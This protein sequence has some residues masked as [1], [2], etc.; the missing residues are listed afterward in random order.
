VKTKK[1]ILNKISVTLKSIFLLLIVG[2]MHSCSE[3]QMTIKED[4]RFKIFEEKINKTT[5]S[6]KR[7]QFVD[8]LINSAKEGDYPIF[9][10]DSTVVL[11]YQ[12][13]KDSAFVLGDMANWQEFLPMTKIE[14][15]NL[16][17]FRAQYEPSARLEYWV[18][19]DKDGS[20]GVDPL[21]KY[22]VLNGFGPMSELTMPRYDRHP[23]FDKYVFGKKGSTE[24][25][26]PLKIPAGVL[27]YEHQLHVYLPSGY[28]EEKQKY[29]AVYIQ[30]GIDYVEFAQTPYVINKLIQDKKIEP[31]IAV[32]VT[33]PNRFLPGPPNRMTEYGLNDDYV[34]FFAEELV[35]FI[36]QKYRTKKDP[37]SRLVVGDSFGGLISAYI[38]FVRPDI[39][40]LGYSQSGYL[41]F[42]KDKLIEAY[43]NSSRKNIRLYV[44]IGTYERAVGGAFL[45]S[46]ET[47]FFMANRRF[48]KVLEKKGYDFVYHEYFEGHTW[49]NW[50]RHLIDGLI[51]FF[52]IENK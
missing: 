51:H 37:N 50:R 18:S 41:S 36:D 35:P 43:S 39:F 27:P 31:V 3:H 38:P 10:D 19:T 17:Y 14:T 30:D 25:T 29:P 46:S 23:Y 5:D 47:D 21:N 52:G 28:H 44:D 1:V 12:S 15:T 8:Q 32:F 42:Q 40:Q 45:P 16:F 48:K 24:L 34:T 7:Q 13:D 6:N 4:Q 2:N 9:E 20:V 33:P 11:L 26:K 22:K 49:G